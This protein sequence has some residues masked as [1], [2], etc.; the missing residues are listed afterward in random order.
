[1]MVILPLWATEVFM[2]RKPTELRRKLV[3]FD[4]KTWH[5][6]NL[7]S[8]GSMKTFQEL[9]DEAFRDLLHKYGRPTDL[10][11]IFPFIIVST[12]AIFSPNERDG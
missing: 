6:F 7:L 11:P 2:A 5:A 3:G 10:K 8:R 4:E 9:A 12:T 1:M